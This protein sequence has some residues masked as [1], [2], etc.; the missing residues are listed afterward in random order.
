MAKHNSDN[1]TNILLESGTNEVEFLEF[2]VAGQHFGVNVAKVS[3]SL[4]LKNMQL[5]KLPGGSPHVLGTVYFRHRP[6]SV[7]SMRSL[8]GIEQDDTQNRDSQ[9]LLVME[10]NQHIN[11][12]VIDH[13]LGIRR[14]TW[15]NF[16]P[17][18][19]AGQEQEVSSVT[20]TISVEDRLILV[21]EMEQLISKVDP[22]LAFSSTTDYAQHFRLGR[23]EINI[24]YAEDSSLVRNFTLNKL[25]EA[26]FKKFTSFPTGAKALDYVMSVQGE[27]VDVIL[28]DIEMPEMDGLTFCRRIKTDSRTQAIPFVFYSSMINSQMSAKC[29]GVGG[30]ASFSKPEIHEVF[31][32][33][34]EFANARRQETSQKKA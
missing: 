2:M 18:N 14:V 5:I 11:G 15:E 3:Q 28:S 25:E 33:I 22:S 13:V 19:Q 17:L 8:L 29:L 1:L 31:L 9:L 7:I 23:E 21:L 16:V 32:A 34:E 12:F 24:V 4:V 27:G 20:G 26:G 30:S 6:I 10:F